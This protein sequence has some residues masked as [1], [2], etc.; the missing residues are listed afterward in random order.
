MRRLLDF[1]ESGCITCFVN[2]NDE[3]DSHKSDKCDTS[4][5]C[6]CNPE[7]DEFRR[8]LRAP[9]GI[10]FGCWVSLVCRISQEIIHFTHISLQHHADHSGTMG[11][12]CQHEGIAV[13]LV[14]TYII[15]SDIFP[16]CPL[17]PEGFRPKPADEFILWLKQVSGL[18][19]PN[20][21]RYNM[22]AFM[23]WFSGILGIGPPVNV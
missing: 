10:C 23:A 18:Y 17:L 20:L 3:W 21:P 22:W 11:F 8:A 5:L 13:R 12:R 7:F 15:G 1:F 4:V 6:G 9:V 14:Y 16:P 19:Y 2:G